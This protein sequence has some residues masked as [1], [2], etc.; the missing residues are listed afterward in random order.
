MKRTGNTRKPLMLIT[1][2]FLASMMITSPTEAHAPGVVLTGR[3]TAT[4]DGVLSAGEWTNAG[5]ADFSVN[6]P[7]GGTTPGTVCAMNDATNLYLLV[8][9]ARTFV[10]P[11]NSVGFEFDNDHDGI[12]PE[13]GDDALV[14]NPAF[15]FFDDVRTNL[16]PCPL[17]PT[18]FCG[19]LDT[20]AGGTNDGSGTFGNNG[21]F[22]VYE[23]SHPLN[24]ADDAHDFSL[25]PGDTV[26]FL[27]SLRMST[28]TG[29]PADFARTSFPVGAFG[30]I[31]IAS[32]VIS[33]SIDIHP[34]SD[35]N[36][37]NPKSRGTIP[38]A[39]LSSSTFDA[40][41]SVDKTSLT[42]GRT[43]NENSLA[44]CNG[45][46]SNVNG[47]A[48]TDLMCHFDT[49]KTGFQSGD[50]TGKLKGKTVSGTPIEGSDSVRIVP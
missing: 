49:Q 33:I 31:V 30:D 1:L 22:S 37:V 16:P 47:D 7:G 14:I 13:E 15:G 45:S 3:G 24:S 27:L 50:T 11:S 12:W 39:I 4:I 8:R 18:I 19:P 41:A 5:C 21:T 20:A 29:D 23:F 36:P 40:F 28:G 48:F 32:P 6:T 43:G 2:V 44:F 35:P 25:T 46:P 17:P 38:V 42:F 26:G 34:G 9:F 10:D